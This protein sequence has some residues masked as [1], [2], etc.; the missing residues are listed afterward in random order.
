MIRRVGKNREYKTITE[1]YSFA[2]KDDI[3][4]IDPGVYNEIIN[5]TANKYV[6]LVGNT[7]NP[8]SG[9]VVIQS[10]SLHSIDISTITD[11]ITLLIEGICLINKGTHPSYY[12]LNVGSS[13]NLSIVF[14]RCI[15]NANLSDYVINC[16]SSTACGAITLRNSKIVWKNLKGYPRFIDNAGS[17]NVS[18]IKSIFTSRIDNIPTSDLRYPGVYGDNLINSSNTTT[19]NV[20][21]LNNLFD[22]STTTYSSWSGF[23]SS[24]S[25][26][27][28]F[29]SGNSKII[30]TM[31]IYLRQIRDVDSIV[32]Y[33][34]NN[35]IDWDVIYSHTELFSAHY[36]NL[37]NNNSFRYYRLNIFCAYGSSELYEY[38]LY[39]GSWAAALPFDY[40]VNTETVGYGPYYGNYQ[41]PVPKQYYFKGKVTDTNSTNILLDNVAFDR[42]RTD[43]TITLTNSNLTATSSTSTNDLYRNAMVS[44][45]RNQGKWYWEII[46]NNNKNPLFKSR[47]GVGNIYT[48]LKEGIGFDAN[49]WGYEYYTGNIIHDGAV[50]STGI[51]CAHLDRIGVAYDA[52]NGKLWF[53]KNGVWM[54]D[55]N[56]T[57]GSNPTFDNL[58]GVLFPVVS[59]YT[60]LGLSSTV[61]LVFSDNSLKYPI[62]MGYKFYGSN[63]VWNVKAFNNDTKELMNMTTTD[64]NDNTFFVDTTYSGAHF[65]I[66]EDAAGDPK[67]NDLVFGTLLPKELV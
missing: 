28:D 53:S 47:C 45:G 9:S 4:W 34:S 23:G 20:T 58:Y 51:T 3:L 18:I 25:I 59:L 8:N 16:T 48:N 11:T 64:A 38:S 13:P 5:M 60:K 56:P 62:P 61:T 54:L 17:T 41:A 30:K 33:G 36:I 52:Y 37:N 50:V 67:Y 42:N 14:N 55:G 27:T 6:H 57:I 2:A 43:S 29:G 22:G 35:N 21:N 31:Y 10:Y 32:F 26:N 15:L 46:V 39:D 1:A 44:L 63:V 24:F 66:C 12:V 7:T 40:V 65:I 19:S 49:S